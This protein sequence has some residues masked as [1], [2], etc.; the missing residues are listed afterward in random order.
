LKLKLFQFIVFNKSKGRAL[1]NSEVILI[2]VYGNIN[3]IQIIFVKNFKTG[4]NLVGNWKIL[5]I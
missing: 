5:A 3:I 1:K 2:E 4:K